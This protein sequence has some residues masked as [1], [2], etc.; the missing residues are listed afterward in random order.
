M[1]AKSIENIIKERL[2]PDEAKL[3]LEE[4]SSVIKLEYQLPPLVDQGK[5]KGDWNQTLYNLDITED[6]RPGELL[7]IDIIKEMIKSPPVRF[8]LEMK[9]AS[10]TSVFRDERSWK[11]HCPDKDLQ[12]VITSNL[13][14]ILPKMALDFSYSSLVFGVS[15]QELV[16]EWKTEYELGISE[17]VNNKKWIVAKIPNAVNP[18]T[19]YCI[20]RKKNGEFNGFVQ[21]PFG[22]NNGAEEIVVERDSSLIIPYNEKFRN[23]WGESFLTPIYPIW[24]WYEVVL[25]SMVKYMERTA[26]PVAVAGAP[27]RGKIVRPDGS[28][29]DALTWA[30]EI[31][32]NV[33]K[34]NAAVLPTD[35]DEKGNRIWTLDYL[36]STERAQ[37]FID[38]LELLNQMIIRAGMSADRSMTQSS[39]GVGSY[40]I[41]EVH[42]RATASHNENILIQ[43]VHYLN[44]YFLPHYANY[45]MGN[46]A[47]PVW[48]E[49]QGLDPRDQDNLKTIINAAAQSE[50]MQEAMVGV[51]WRT[52]FEL[53]N[54]PVLS[55][56][57]QEAKMK[58]IEKK[59]QE[60]FEQQRQMAMDKAN[61]V[62]KPNQKPVTNQKPTPGKPKEKKLTDILESMLL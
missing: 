4:I 9:R 5:T 12:A 28:K 30:M 60:A 21:R 55:K 40:N 3:V 32:S 61:N 50:S 2:Q 35:T 48:I 53:N 33:A 27:S 34:S 17:T 8:A 41:G 10:I 13:R 24:F 54:Y 56:E 22:I 39:G 11:V 20:K 14:K 23:L 37:P 47:P 51:D 38:V 46:S 57:E 52:L 43:W 18:E 59:K 44:T 7:D 31:A 42:A 16:W 15:F 19:I 1:N 25:R 26:T 49:T 36:T 58:E 6:F 29:V 62:Q 45:N